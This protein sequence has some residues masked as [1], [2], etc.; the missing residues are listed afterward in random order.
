MGTPGLQVAMAGMPA[1]SEETLKVHIE[2]QIESL[3]NL[4]RQ[5]ESRQASKK[6]ESDDTSTGD[7]KPSADEANVD[8]EMG[9]DPVADP[10]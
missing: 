1:L 3:Q 8:A 10:L 2:W 5:I 9:A 6:A 4:L 7:K